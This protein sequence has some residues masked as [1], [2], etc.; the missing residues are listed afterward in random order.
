MICDVNCVQDISPLKAV[1]P[2]SFKA[3]QY[4]VLGRIP[5]VR[6]CVGCNKTFD[7]VGN[8]NGMLLELSAQIVEVFQLLGRIVA[9]KAEVG[10]ILE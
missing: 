2:S 7:D 6:N 8:L 9:G 10:D 4:V 3:E 1:R 5:F